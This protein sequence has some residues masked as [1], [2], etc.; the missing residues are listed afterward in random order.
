MGADRA[1]NYVEKDFVEVAKTA[2]GGKGCDLILDMVGGDY[3]ARNLEALAPEGR[4][5]QIA[6]QKGAKA[7][8]FLPTIMMKR[9]TLTGSVLRPRT[10]EQKGAI[11]RTLHRQLWPLLEKGDIAPIIHETFPLAQASDAHALM[12][13]SAHIG[14][15]VLEV[16]DG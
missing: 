6:V 9:L 3:V 15:I 5:V 11:A 14:K 13:S 12:E 7:E 16:E 10:V 4:L 2:N 1:I 8:L